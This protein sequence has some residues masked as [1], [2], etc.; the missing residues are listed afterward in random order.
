MYV[1]VICCQCIN[2]GSYPRITKKCRHESSSHGPP[3]PVGQRPPRKSWTDRLWEVLWVGLLTLLFMLPAA[4]AQYKPALT[5]VKN[6]TTY[7]VARDATYSQTMEFQLRVETEKG[8]EL[9]GE[10]KITYNSTME[11]VE[12]VEA[13]TLLR[14]GT[15]V[16]V[17]AD[18]IRTQ[19]AVDSES[20]IYDD[21][22]EKVIIYSKVEVGAQVYYR[23]LLGYLRLGQLPKICRYDLFGHCQAQRPSRRW[24]SAVLILH[25]LTR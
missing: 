14:D 4:Y 19:D 10:Q 24:R 18:K 2:L 9:A 22:K 3:S 16:P 20:A 25:Q 21:Y 1:M 6:I 7:Q 5:V 15:R 8:I 13:Y 23:G 17:E 12:V 11:V